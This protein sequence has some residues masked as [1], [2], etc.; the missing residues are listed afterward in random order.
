MNLVDVIIVNY[1]STDSLLACIGS[2]YDSIQEMPINI[3]VID[4]SSN[5]GVDRV[6]SLYPEV[7]LT[8]NPSNIGFGRA[9]NIGIKHTKAPYTLI[10]NP[11]TLLLEGFFDTALR[12]MKENQDVGILGPKILDPDGS[13]QG[14]ARSFPTPLTAF[15]G[16][17]SLLTQLFPKNR[18]TRQNILT[19]ESDGT[20]P[21]EVDWVSGACFFARREALE[22]VGYM[23]ERFFMYWEDADLCRR[24]WNGGWKILYFPKCAVIHYVGVSSEQLVFRSVFEFHK[25]I[26]LLNEKYFKPSLWFIKPLIIAV[27]SLRLGFVFASN[28]IQVWHKNQRLVRLREKEA[29]VP[30]NRGRIRILRLI[31]RLN[32]GGP[33]I[34]VHLLTKGLD[35]RKFQSILVTGKI[36]PQEGDMS[37]LFDSLYESPIHVPELQREISLKADVKAFFRIFRIICQERPDIVHT[38]TAKAGTSAR[39]AVFLYNLFNRSNIRTIHTFHGHIFKGYFSKAK[40]FLFVLVERILSRLTDVIVAISETQKKEL[41]E[42][43]SIAPPDKIKTIQLGFNL[44]PFL[45]SKA[46]RGQLR[47]ILGINNDTLLV[48]TVGRL[49]PIKNHMMFFKAA[50][51][52]LGQNPGLSVAFVVVGDGELRQELEAYCREEGIT[53]HVYFCGWIKQIPSVYHDLDILTLTSLNEGTPVSIIEAMASSVPVIATDA[54]GVIDLLGPPTGTIQ[55][56]GFKV[57]ER[58]ILCPKNDPYSFSRGL[59]LLLEMDKNEKTALLSRSRKFVRQHFSEDR[60]IKD[61]EALYSDLIQEAPEKNLFPIDI[62]QKS[63]A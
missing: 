11:D 41:T 24:M 16:R 7:C 34:H 6:K 45:K 52:F 63:R 29:T 36:S 25:S 5:D 35:S 2:I 61:I 33:A 17:K 38:H 42:E 55:T 14:S 22:E 43:F 54:G 1:N 48:G 53:D 56:D 40:S 50:K 8:K 10:L 44:D 3:Y 30:G 57:C 58:G 26:Y 18:F 49:A 46:F 62:L 37:Y 15:F 27:F 23:D 13:I 28:G 9:V 19:F 12:Y 31:A 60:L 4:N 59:K 32:I 47:N 39:L 21:M 20:S 51:I